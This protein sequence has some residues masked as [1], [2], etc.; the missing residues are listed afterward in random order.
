MLHS[1]IQQISIKTVGM[2]E[3]SR[4]Q[5]TTVNRTGTDTHLF[6]IC[7]SLLFVLSFFDMILC[8]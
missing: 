7:H 2:N 1:R 3:E 8:I 6:S 5:V 4:S